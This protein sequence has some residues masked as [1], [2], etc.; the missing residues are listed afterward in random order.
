MWIHREKSLFTGN[1]SYSSEKAYENQTMKLLSQLY[2]GRI[3]R[4]ETAVRR[5][6][7]A[8][9]LDLMSR[10]NSLIVSHG[11]A[12]PWDEFLRSRVKIGLACHDVTRQVAVRGSS[13]K[14][15]MSFQ[16]IHHK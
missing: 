11:L 16:L 13:T 15:L 6:Q 9:L 8:F 14:E 1:Q 10:K 4:R 7:P 3:I 5:Y 12:N 2:D